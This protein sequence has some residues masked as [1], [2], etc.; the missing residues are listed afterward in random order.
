MVSVRQFA[1]CEFR[2]TRWRGRGDA[3]VK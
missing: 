3:V 1:L 2:G